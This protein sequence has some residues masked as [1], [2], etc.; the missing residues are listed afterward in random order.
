MYFSLLGL[1]RHMLM[2]MVKVNLLSESDREN[3]LL[4][5]IF[6]LPGFPML[7]L[8]EKLNSGS[9]Q[10]LIIVFESLSLQVL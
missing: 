10:Q 2:R 5:N 4:E 8:G 9:L 3:E 1:I 6:V 7:K